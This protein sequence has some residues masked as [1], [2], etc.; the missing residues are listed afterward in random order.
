M[1]LFNS[2]NKFNNNK[3]IVMIRKII[4]VV[5]HNNNKI[6]LFL[7]RL[8]R[9]C[10]SNSWIKNW[11]LVSSPLLKTRYFLSI[12]LSR[13]FK[14]LSNNYRWNKFNSKITIIINSW[15]WLF[16]LFRMNR[17]RLIIL[18]LCL[19]SSKYLCS[20]AVLKII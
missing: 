9:N 17:I 11:V 10:F 3:S 14:I 19:I 1:K 7:A 8:W 15:I 12:I 5:I 16:L 18:L 2:K 6:L 13:R 20:R 4:M